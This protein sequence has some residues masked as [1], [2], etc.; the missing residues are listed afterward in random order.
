MVATILEKETEVARAIAIID[1]QLAEM[2]TKLGALVLAKQ[3]QS[4]TEADRSDAISQV[5]V[6][7]T[8]LSGSRR[9]R[10]ELLSCMQAAAANAQSTQPGFSILFGEENKGSQTGI[11]HGI[12]NNTFHNRE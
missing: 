2:N 9:L 4:E 11:N 1:N 7:Q 3:H 5:A 10:E 8:A 6:E 12:V